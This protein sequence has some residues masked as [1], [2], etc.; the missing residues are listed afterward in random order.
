MLYLGVWTRT[1]FAQTL[2]RTVG[3]LSFFP[4]RTTDVILSNQWSSFAWDG[5]VPGN[6]MNYSEVDLTFMSKVEGRKGPVLEFRRFWG[7]S[8]SSWVTWAVC[9]FWNSSACPHIQWR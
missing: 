8:G 3:V 7:V 9:F 5:K 2:K 6:H 1:L 4:T